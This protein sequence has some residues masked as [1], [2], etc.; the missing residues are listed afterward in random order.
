MGAGYHGGFGQ[1][2]GNSTHGKIF[3]ADRQGKHI[4]GHKN[5]IEGRSIF[6][7]TLKDAETLI[8]KCLKNLN[9]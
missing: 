6:L 3:H 2:K 5:Y 1:T 4:I 8:K 9:R 7:G